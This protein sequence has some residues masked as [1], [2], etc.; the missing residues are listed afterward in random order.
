MSTGSDVTKHP[1]APVF[2]HIT[3]DLC[4]GQ[5]PTGSCHERLRKSEAGPPAPGAL[6]SSCMAK[7]SFQAWKLRTLIWPQ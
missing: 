6:S 4:Q 5:A 1:A 3:Q 7:H 2:L